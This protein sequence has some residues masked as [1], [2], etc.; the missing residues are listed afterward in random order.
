MSENVHKRAREL[1]LSGRI[2]EIGTA[3]RR[4]LETHMDECV[5]CAGF[6]SALGDAV[7]A[8]RIP[9]VAATT[10]LVGATQR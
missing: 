7:N 8:V 10:S 5:E 4:W 1:A 9:Q 3:E 6:S 2:E